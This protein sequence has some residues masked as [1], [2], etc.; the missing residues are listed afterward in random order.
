MVN[1]NHAKA[2]QSAAFVKDQRAVFEDLQVLYVKE[3]AVE[4]GKPDQVIYATVY[5]TSV[6][7]DADP[8]GKNEARKEA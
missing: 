3:G 8:R 1:Q 2:P 5:Q 7:K 6:R 4:L